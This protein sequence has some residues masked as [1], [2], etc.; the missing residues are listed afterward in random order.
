MDAR[1]RLGSRT[2]KEDRMTVPIKRYHNWC[3]CTHHHAMAEH[4][5]GPYVTFAD[6]LK[7]IADEREICAIIC[8]AVAMGDK[9]ATA[10]EAALIIR[11]EE[12]K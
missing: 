2:T 9:S 10:W 3:A 7:A 6:H 1:A 12:T 4:S 11:G 8:D 5:D